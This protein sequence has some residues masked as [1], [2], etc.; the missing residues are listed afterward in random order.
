MIKLIIENIE[1]YNYTL[2]DNDNN[3]YKI[4][5]EFYDIDELPKIGNAIYIN[6]KLLNKINNNVAS[7]GKLDGV[8]GRKIM[9]ENDEDVIGVSI[10]DKVIYLKRYY[11]QSIYKDITNFILETSNDWENIYKGK[12]LFGDL[13]KIETIH[14]K[15]KREKFKVKL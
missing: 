8:Y 12:E 10:H 14:S 9:D 6:N 11:G 3:R 4:N 5:I 7:F 15:D 13:F 1:G 2:K